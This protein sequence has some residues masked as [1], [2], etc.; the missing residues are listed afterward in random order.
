MDSK[1]TARELNGMKCLIETQDLIIAKFEQYS[2]QLR[3]PQL[4][5]EFQKL[6]ASSRNHRNRLMSALENN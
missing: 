6:C 3:E 5:M 4:R 1:I 2:K